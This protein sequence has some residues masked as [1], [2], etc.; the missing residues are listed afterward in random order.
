MKIK[1]SILNSEEF[2]FA[3]SFA[4]EDRKIVEKIY[5]KLVVADFKV[6]YDYTYQAQLVGKDLYTLLRDLYKNKGKYVVCFIS[7]H[8]TK[9]IWTNLE[10]TAVKERLMSTFFAGDFLI[11]ILIGNPEMLED[12]PS[13]IGF[14][15]HKSI[16]DTVN[17]LKEKINTTILEDNF[18]NNV[19]NCISYIRKQTFNN[20]NRKNINAALSDENELI[21]KSMHNIFVL[22]FY[23]DPIVQTP[24]IL[25]SKKEHGEN[26]HHHENF[27]I[28]IITWNKRETLTFSIHDFDGTANKIIKNQTINGIVNSICSYVESYIGE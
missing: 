21:I 25:I 28:F 10:F 12:I 11:P 9:K 7:E 14:Y 22:H 17:M 13:F 19:N 27:P 20:L 26:I 8:Y 16:N 5:K 15:Q 23:S 24:C 1:N 6:F 2:D 4:G 3:F 18:L